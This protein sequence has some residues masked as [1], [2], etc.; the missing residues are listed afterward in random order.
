[1]TRVVCV[2]GTILGLALG[3]CA[4]DERWERSRAE[5]CQ[6]L[7]L[8]GTDVRQSVAAI[9]ATTA[10]IGQLSAEERPA[11]CAATEHD[12]R[13]IGARLDGFRR[14][15]HALARGRDE[16]QTVEDAGFV[17]T[18]GQDAVQG[19]D[20]S[21]CQSGQYDVAAKSVAAIEKKLDEALSEGLARCQA[22]AK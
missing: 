17:L 19:Y 1:M 21:A 18:L 20:R 2:L 3:G 10:A 11:A 14:G 15:A 13:V 4:R 8:L 6:E 7:G 22:V 16:G 5:Y 9:G 12:L